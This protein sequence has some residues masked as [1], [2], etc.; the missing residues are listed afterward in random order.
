MFWPPGSGFGTRDPHCGIVA[1]RG[2]GGQ[3]NF[4]KASRESL[5]LS[6]RTCIIQAHLP[7]RPKRSAVGVN[8][9]DVARYRARNYAEARRV[10]RTVKKWM[11]DDPHNEE[12][13]AYFSE[14]AGDMLGI[15]GNT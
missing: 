4:T 5:S 9:L 6:S 8:A 13:L 10:Y 12:G 14:E 2:C 1:R 11:E 3:P 7:Q 15:D